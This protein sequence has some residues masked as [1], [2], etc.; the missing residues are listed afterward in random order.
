MVLVSNRNTL[1]DVPQIH[2]SAL[3][4]ALVVA[5]FMAYVCLYVHITYKIKIPIRIVT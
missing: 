1:E 3:Q 4:W 5:Q 2:N